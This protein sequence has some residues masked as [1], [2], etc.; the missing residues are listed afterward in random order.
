MQLFH[1]SVISTVL[2]LLIVQGA[3]SERVITTRFMQWL[4]G[5]FG[6][7]TTALLVLPPLLLLGVVIAWS[8]PRVISRAIFHPLSTL[9]ALGCVLVASAIKTP[10]PRQPGLWAGFG[11]FPTLVCL[12]LALLLFFFLGSSNSITSNKTFLIILKVVIPTIALIPY[13]LLYIQPPNGLINLGD[14][15]YH[16]LD[17]LLA[18]LM[19]AYPLGEYSPQYSGMLGW[20]VYPLK[21]FSLS[22]EMTMLAVIIAVNL[23]NLLIPLLVLLIVKGIFPTLPKII[24]MTAFVVVWGVAGSDRGASV[25]LREFAQFGQ[26]V[27]VLCV[28]WVLVRMLKSGGSS[29]QR[30][31][32]FV[33]L[34]SAFAILGSAD[35]GLSFVI[36]LLISLSLATYRKWLAVKLY[37]LVILGILLGIVGYCAVLVVFGKRPSLESWVGI[38]SGAKSLYGGGAI[39]AFGPHLIVMAIAVT[40]IALGLQGVRGSS[41]NAQEVLFRVASLS[42]G[43]WIL[44][45]LVKFLLAPHA[46]G[47]PPLFIP[48]FIAF[49][50][51]IGH[52]RIN[53]PSWNQL[54]D[55]L[56]ML[57]LLFI[58][59][60]PL[61]ALWQFPDPLDELRRISGRYVNT[62]NWSSIP[63]RVSDGWSPTALKIYDDFITETSALAEKLESDGSQV[64]YFGIF[65]HT[66]ELLTGVD[67]LIGIPA[68]ESLR[69]GSTQEKLGC[70]PVDTRMPQFVIVYASPFPC[71][72]Y[73]LD[74]KNSTDKFFVFR[75]VGPPPVNP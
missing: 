5:A 6:D 14:T 60:L 38:R 52:F 3:Q 13:G 37:R 27:P 55:R 1:A 68:P 54:A 42:L 33:G 16:V 67:N 75:R 71:P 30:L 44:A 49:V 29:Q 23:F 20:L 18:P 48:T 66:L 25:Q 4:Y 35:Y 28:I 41:V 64:G 2:L 7:L 72:N 12:F 10:L 36:A 22:G 19:G 24:T 70:L 31:A 53:S 73:K 62:T 9:L 26:F 11:F 57:P 17:E 50:M 43:L 46:V 21:F 65:G 56:Q 15:S 51:I 74:L 39:D 8:S 59:A 58:T 47:L 40:A 63:G 69:F 61:A 45:L 32:F 34:A